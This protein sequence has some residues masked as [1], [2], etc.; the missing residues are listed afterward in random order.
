MAENKYISIA[1][2]AKILRISRIAVYKK[3]KKG[4]IKAMKVGRNYVIPSSVLV[5]NTINIKGRPLTEAQKNTIE[6]AIRKTVEEYGEVLKKLGS[7]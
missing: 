6:K 3:V 5:R 4:D 2:L 7:E 1:E